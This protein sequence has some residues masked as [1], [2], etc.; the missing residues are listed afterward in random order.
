MNSAHIY[1][2]EGYFSNKVTFL[3]VILTVM[4]VVLHAK[5]PERFGLPLDWGNP[6]IYV[7]TAFTRMAVPS[8]FFISGMLLFRGYTAQT[9]PRKLKSR[10]WT[11]VVPYLLWNT[12][13]AIVFL[14]MTRIPLISSRMNMGIA[15]QTPMEFVRAILF[16]RHSDLW[17]VGDLILFTIVSPLILA[18]SKW[19]YPSLILL[20]LSIL[21]YF[22]ALPSYKSPLHWAPMYI[23]GALY[24]CNMKEMAKNIELRARYNLILTVLGILFCASLLYSLF[25]ESLYLYELVSP[26]ALWVFADFMFGNKISAF[27]KKQWMNYTFFIFCS[28]HFLEN[29]LQKFCVM[30]FEPSPFVM[31]AVYFITPFITIWILVFLCNIIKDTLFYKLLCGNR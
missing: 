13:Y 5:T 28:H 1:D 27:N 30:A 19:K 20:V 10:F 8:F 11:L 23:A 15:I 12:I 7:I 6:L 31:N 4:V 25:T 26:F 17:F 18:I 29:I 14:L 16:S 2:T 24:G 21:Y 3:N 22:F 9:L